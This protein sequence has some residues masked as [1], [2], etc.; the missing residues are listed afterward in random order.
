MQ[1]LLYTSHAPKPLTH[2]DL[3]SILAVARKLNAR[4]D[5]TGMLIYHD[6][7]FLQLLEGPEAEV[8]A[9]YERIRKDRRH[10]SCTR[11]INE[12][13]PTRIFSEWRMSYQAYDTLGAGQQKQFVDIHRFAARFAEDEIA[14]HPAAATFVMAFLSG[15]R[16]VDLAV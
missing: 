4:D 8:T 13:A 7:S 10:Q 9:C 15:F 14:Q 2:G 3:E 6:G 12:P 11:I 16:R 1:R 5:I